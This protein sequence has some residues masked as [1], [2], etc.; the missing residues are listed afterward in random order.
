MTLTGLPFLFSINMFGRKS[1]SMPR[2]FARGRELDPETAMAVAADRAADV[3][4][5]KIA[6]SGGLRAAAEV[7]T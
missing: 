7:L 1:R 4:A 3:F 5:V 2:L 6:Q